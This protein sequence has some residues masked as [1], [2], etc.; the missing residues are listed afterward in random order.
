PQRLGLRG[1]PWLGRRRGGGGDLRGGELDGRLVDRLDLGQ[2][3]GGDLR[4]LLHGNPG[5][6]LVLREVRIPAGLGGRGLLRGRLRRDRFGGRGPRFRGGPFGGLL[7]VGRG[8]RL[9]LGLIQEPGVIVRGGGAGERLLDLAEDVVLRAGAG[10]LHRALFVLAGDGEGLRLRCGR[11]FRE[12]NA[13]TVGVGG[14]EVA[15][16]VGREAGIG[17]GAPVRGFG[18]FG[19]FDLG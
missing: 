11:I 5:G 7:R 18:G 6:R 19:G 12:G 16:D 17:L 2:R 13:D 8:L 1:C 3:E 9:G 15:G 14:D 4:R 10:F